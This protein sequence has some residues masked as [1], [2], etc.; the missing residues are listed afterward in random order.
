VAANILQSGIAFQLTAGERRLA[1]LPLFHAAVVPTAFSPIGR[2]ASIY[3]MQ[4]SQPADVVGC[5]LSV[6][7]CQKSLSFSL[8]TTDN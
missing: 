6:V 8:L 1:V 4:D 3:V 7:S 2:G 5:W